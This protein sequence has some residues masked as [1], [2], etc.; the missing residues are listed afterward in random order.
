VN[1]GYLLTLI[2]LKAEL[3]EHL[4]AIYVNKPLK[5]EL[6]EHLFAIYVNKT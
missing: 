5:A 3:E 1:F 6:E 2:D 4:F